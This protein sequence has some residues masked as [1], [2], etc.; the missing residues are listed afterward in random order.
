MGCDTLHIGGGEPFFNMNSLKNTLK[1][2]QQE[3]I[4]IEYVETNSSWYKD[5]SSACRT[6]EELQKLSMH[7]LLISISPFHNEYVP[8]NKVKGVIAA[9]K[10]VG[11]SPFPWIFD[12]YREVDSFPDN[13]PHAFSEYTQKFGRHYL[14][15]VFQRYWIHPGGRALTTF[16]EQYGQKSVEDLVND[17][18]PCIELENTIHFH[19]DLY[20]NYIPGL[21][22]GIQ[23]HSSDIGSGKPAP[24]G[25]YPFLHILY[26]NGIQGFYRVAAEEFGFVP[27]EKYASKCHLC[28]EI[29]KFL[30][31][32]K[33]LKTPDF[34][35][36]SFYQNL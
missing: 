29:R 30:V 35:P 15:K 23:V 28:L 10:D 25:K 20:E 17:N 4:G 9:C 1:A 14:K 7:R 18:S 21:C 6:L 5:H 8:F 3:G 26:N 31:L 12:F 13:Q 16:I 36:I 27:Q 33:E 2:A 34:G 32:E 24:A 11:I 19:F 22:S